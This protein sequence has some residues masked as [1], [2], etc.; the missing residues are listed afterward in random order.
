VIPLAA[1]FLRTHTIEIIGRYE[2]LAGELDELRALTRGALID[3]LP[4]FIDALGGWVEAHVAGGPAAPFGLLADGHAMQRFALGVSL[5]TVT[6]EYTLLRNVILTS[7]LA[8]D[9]SPEVRRELIA[10]NLGLDLAVMEAVKRYSEQR[11]A[12]R[13]RFISILGHDLR[14]PLS[15]IALGADSLISR[16]GAEATVGARI[17]RSAQRMARMINDVLDFARGHLGGGIPATPTRNDLGKLCRDTVAEVAHGFP[18]RVVQ[19][20]LE[21][22]LRGSWD[23]ERLRQALSNLLGNAIAHGRDPIV[24]RAWE[25]PDRRTVFASVAN[26]GGDIPGDVMPEL[27]QP[28]RTVKRPGSSGI[29]LGLY[30]VQQVALSHGGLCTVTS[31]EGTTTFTLTLPR[32]PVEQTPGRP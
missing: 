13:D 25:A 21:G 19:L 26:G 18:D 20:E 12:V 7:L 15:A 32:V 30:I 2:E 6:R 29:G 8:L 27:F 11:D 5:A 9:S 22:D 28:F 23:G 16:A 24:V 31:V 14:G 3:H 4:E 10:V 1:Q 17:A